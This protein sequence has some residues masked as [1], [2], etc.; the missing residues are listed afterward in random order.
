MVRFIDDRTVSNEHYSAIDA[1]YG[2]DVRT[3]LAGH[4]LKV[5]LLPCFV[6]PAGGLSAGELR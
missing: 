2:E 3:A 5:H 4:S 1:Q 6:D